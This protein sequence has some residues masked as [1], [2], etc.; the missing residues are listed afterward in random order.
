MDCKLIIPQ[1][2]DNK[3]FLSCNDPLN[4]LQYSRCCSRDARYTGPDR[5]KLTR[6]IKAQGFMF[7]PLWIPQAN[8]ASHPPEL[9]ERG[10]LTADGT[11]AQFYS[12]AA[13]ISLKWRDSSL[14]LP[15]LTNHTPT[16]IKTAPLYVSEYHD[17]QR[18]TFPTS[19]DC[20]EKSAR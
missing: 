11:V 17:H 19:A 9:W 6:G 5:Y 7:R 14:F 16:C 18:N 15:G 2:I 20:F 12:L 8:P 13:R 3:S 10:F 4:M 1:K